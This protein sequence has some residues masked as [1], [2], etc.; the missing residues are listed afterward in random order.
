[1]AEPLLI[2][3]A[4]DESSTALLTYEPGDTYIGHLAVELQ[5]ERPGASGLQALMRAEC[6]VAIMAP[7]NDPED[8]LAPYLEGLVEDWRGWP[9]AREW[10]PL[11]PQLRIAATHHGGAVEFRFTIREDH[12]PRAWTSSVS[13]IV[14]PGES[15]TRIARWSR[16][17]VTGEELPVE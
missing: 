17:L 16:S 11:D 14:T 6:R 10:R 9:G 5:A 2:R 1:V 8:G 3:S 15:L 13:L 12:T 7:E 4:A